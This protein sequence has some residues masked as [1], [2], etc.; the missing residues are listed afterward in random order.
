MKNILNF[1]KFEES[2]LKGS[3][4]PMYHFTYDIFPIISSDEFKMRNT[5]ARKALGREWSNSW[6][7]NIDFSDAS[8]FY[9]IEADADKLKNDGIRFYPVDEWALPTNHNIPVDRK[10]LKSKHFGKSNFDKVKLGKRGTKH[11]LD[12]PKIP[13]IF[14]LE[15][16]FEERTYKNIKN[17]GKYIISIMIEDDVINYKYSTYNSNKNLIA[18]YLKKYPHIRIK[19]FNKNN[20][21]KQVDITD[22]FIQTGVKKPSTMIF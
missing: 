13:L 11:G 8:S 21:K 3:R 2:Y 19:S 4:Q 12:L 20:R 6:T 10:S 9:I 22:K 16:E 15:T 7:R 1:Q 5:S 17:L 18:E 14:G